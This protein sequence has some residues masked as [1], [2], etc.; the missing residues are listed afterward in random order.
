MT[1]N[2]DY[3]LA[4]E[5]LEGVMDAIDKLVMVAE[6]LIAAIPDQDT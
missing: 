3:D 6:K 1:D 5:C 2:D 4:I